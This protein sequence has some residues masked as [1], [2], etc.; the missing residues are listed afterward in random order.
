MLATATLPNAGD[1]LTARPSPVYQG[2]AAQPETVFGDITA[3]DIVSFDK[4]DFFAMDS[5]KTRWSSRRCGS[6]RRAPGPSRRSRTRCSW[7]S[8]RS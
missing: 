5:S 7:T 4:K 1:G 3:A 8:D 6:T 2:F